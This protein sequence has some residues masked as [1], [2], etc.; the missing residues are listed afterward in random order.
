MASWQI[1][2]AR[3]DRPRARC[4]RAWRV[5]DTPCVGLGGLSQPYSAVGMLLPLRAI[6]RKPGAGMLQETDQ[7]QAGFVAIFL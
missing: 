7:S 1:A 5:S 4:G 3:T 2:G 6:L